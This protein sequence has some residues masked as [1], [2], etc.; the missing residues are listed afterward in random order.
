M[1]FKKLSNKIRL[2]LKNTIKLPMRDDLA[3]SEKSSNPKSMPM[4]LK[5]YM[6]TRKAF[7]YITRRLWGKLG[8]MKHPIAL[9][10]STMEIFLKQNSL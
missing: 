2:R 10:T 1:R 4:F 9:A 8:W 3:V 6:G 7:K 5:A